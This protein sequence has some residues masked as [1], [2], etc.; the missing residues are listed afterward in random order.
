[1][2]RY[3]NISILEAT[4]GYNDTTFH[5]VIYW[6]HLTVIIGTYLLA[7]GCSRFYEP[8]ICK[9]RM[10]EDVVWILKHPAFAIVWLL[11]IIPNY[12]T[13]P[14]LKVDNYE[15]FYVFL[16]LQL[17]ELLDIK[18]A[19]QYALIFMWN[20]KYKNPT[21]PKGFLKKISTNLQ[22]EIPYLM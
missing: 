4:S 22:P 1:M 20:I 10:L 15:M 9:K 21:T 13:L 14:I 5:K 18:Y 6:D 12:G 2:N 11:F 16:R 8:L 3:R 17:F 19:Q 7:S